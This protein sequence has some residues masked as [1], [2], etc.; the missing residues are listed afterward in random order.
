MSTQKPLPPAKPYDDPPESEVQH[1][2]DEIR[3]ESPLKSLGEAFSDVILS[4]D[5]DET[6]PLA[7]TS[8]TPAKSETTK[9]R[10]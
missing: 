4:A 7:G 8:P 3:D 1:S 9:K 6:R 2:A 5:E 10:K